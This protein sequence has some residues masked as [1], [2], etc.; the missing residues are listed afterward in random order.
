MSFFTFDQR[1]GTL[2]HRTFDSTGAFLISELERLDQTLYEPLAAVT[3][4]R[5]IAVR[6]DVTIG[7]EASSFMKLNFF[8]PGGIQPTG[9]NWAAKNSTAITGVGTDL[10]KTVNPLNLWATELAYTIPEL[11]SSQQVGR[12]IDSQKYDAMRLKYNMD[13]DEQVYVG[14]AQ[15]GVFGLSNQPTVSTTNVVNGASGFSTWANKT[16]AEIL[17][18]VNTVLNAAWAAT[19]WAYAPTKLLIPPIQFGILQSQLISTAGSSNII[20][21]LKKNNISY[22]LNGAE[23]DIQPVKWLAG[24]GVGG[25]NRMVAYTQDKGRVRIP[26][27]PLLNT[28]LQYQGIHLQ[29]YY[30]CKMGV[31]EIT[32]TEFMAY[33]DGI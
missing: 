32:N 23:L 33:A 7:D 4:M 17:A 26:L 27:T 11:M 25:T 19:G 21:Y 9:K 15:M 13:V 8:A 1:A 29:T 16:P 5:D 2:D 22:T 30:Y 18:D 14:D 12:P 10:Q 24:R 20:E 28:P 3:W 6:D 31:V